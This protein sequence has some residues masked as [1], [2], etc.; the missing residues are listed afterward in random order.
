MFS[1]LTYRPTVYKTGPRVLYFACQS[2]VS[3]KQKC[4]NPN[5]SNDAFT[6]KDFPVS[7]TW[8]TG[9]TGWAI[10]GLD[11]KVLKNMDPQLFKNTH[12]SHYYT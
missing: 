6:I 12:I 7:F 4:C 1:N 9:F 11:F 10:L 8:F 5:M 2:L 3:W